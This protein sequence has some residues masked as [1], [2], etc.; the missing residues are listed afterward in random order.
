MPR[1][2][3]R[4]I[5]VRLRTMVRNTGACPSASPR[6]GFGESIA[7]ILDEATFVRSPISDTE[8]GNNDVRDVVHAI[9]AR[10]KLPVE[11]TAAAISVT[12]GVADLRL[13]QLL[14]HVLVE[15]RRLSRNVNRHW[16][17]PILLDFGTGAAAFI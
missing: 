1:P 9:A 6:A 10:N 13:Y 7:V 4:M 15:L 12:V 14:Q 17:S 2:N 3:D 11:Q 16:S 5:C 8:A